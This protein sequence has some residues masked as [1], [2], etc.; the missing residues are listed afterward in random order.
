[1]VF[2]I[3]IPSIYFWD[4]SWDGAIPE[5]LFRQYCNNSWFDQRKANIDFSL[6]DDLK[7]GIYLSVLKVSECVSAVENE[8][9]AGHEGGHSL[10][11]RGEA[12]TSPLHPSSGQLGGLTYLS[13]R[14]HTQ[15]ILPNYFSWWNMYRSALVVF[16]YVNTRC[17]WGHKPK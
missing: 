12:G 14:A 1:M 10:V 16:R 7:L 17:I 8:G 4:H 3:R 13:Y 5:G 6:Y 11:C 2:K 9:R 15:K